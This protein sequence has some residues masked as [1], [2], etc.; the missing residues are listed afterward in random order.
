MKQ[1]MKK[2]EHL[3]ELGRLKTDIVL[4]G[5]PIIL[6]AVIGPVTAFDIKPWSPWC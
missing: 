1:L 4:C 3:L 5:L 6:E 2:P